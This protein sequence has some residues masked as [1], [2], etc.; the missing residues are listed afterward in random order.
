M[1]SINN[2]KK[3]YTKQDVE[4]ELN[5]FLNTF[6]GNLC[7]KSTEAKERL[8]ARLDRKFA[9]LLKTTNATY[10]GCDI[11]EDDVVAISYMVEDQLA[12]FEY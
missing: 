2:N 8:I 11:D 7:P 9:A 4:A 12:V 3:V 1:A 5:D 6:S 10:Y